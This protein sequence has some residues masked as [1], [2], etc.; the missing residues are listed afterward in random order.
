[1]HLSSCE[2]PVTLRNRYTHENMVVPCGSCPSCQVQKAQ[3]WIVRLEA[4]RQSV[5]YTL[6]FTLT[7]ADEYLP[8]LE[9]GWSDDSAFLP[10][11]LI[12]KQRDFS[13]LRNHKNKKQLSDVNNTYQVPVSGTVLS[14]QSTKNIMRL[15]AD[16]IPYCSVND[17]Q[18]FIKR[19]RSESYRTAY[20]TQKGLTDSQ[21]MSYFIAAEYGPTTLRP[22]FH[23]LLFFQDSR[24]AEVVD[25]CFSSVWSFGL[26]TYEYVNSS[27]SA[28]VAQYVNSYSHLPRIYKQKELRPFHLSSRRVPIGLRSIEDSTIKEIFYSS[29][30]LMPFKDKSTGCQSYVPLW[31]SLENRLFPV[32]PFNSALD[33]VQRFRLFELFAAIPSNNFQSFSCSI[34]EKIFLLI[35]EGNDSILQRYFSVCLPFYD[36]FK[37]LPELII[38]LESE[39]SFIKLYTIARRIKYLCTRFAVSVYKCICCILAYY[40]NKDSYKLETQYLF[41]QDYCRSQLPCFLLNIDLQYFAFLRSLTL[42][43]IQPVDVMRFETFGINRTKLNEIYSDEKVKRKFF[44]S[45]HVTRSHDFV[46]RTSIAHKIYMD[47]HKTRKKNEYLMKHPEF[48][49]LY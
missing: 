34:A 2:H 22:H 3:S 27:A 37:T 35:E 6:F 5:P 18:N 28:Y 31:R 20:G 12:H 19:L 4:E 44:R 30:P 24:L 26:V 7:Y 49:N 36:M 23:G 42:A 16:T 45:I 48:I 10:D 40:E 33:N 29:S 17:A 46:E 32:L 39:S 21:K 8:R 14:E 11:V 9:L 38:Y 41:E 47:S 15:N 13:N 43:M 25:Q 1:M